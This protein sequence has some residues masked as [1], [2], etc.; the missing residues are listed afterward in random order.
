MG[1]FYMVRPLSCDLR[2]RA[3][4]RV[5]C[6]ETIRSVAEDLCVSPS[7]VSKWHQRY[8]QTG[9]VAPAQIGGYKPRILSGEHRLWLLERTA[10]DFTLW[11]LVHELAAR[12][13]KVDYRSVW[14]FVHREGLSYKKKSF[15]QRARSATGKATAG[16]MEKISKSG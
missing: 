5:M 10:N 12:G 2:D 16:A 8:R 7:S 11:G 3:V 9:S 6:G 14:E 15:A 13:I 1:S 4:Q